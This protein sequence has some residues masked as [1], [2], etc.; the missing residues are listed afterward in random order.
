MQAGLMIQV[1]V[2]F[3]CKS[4]TELHYEI[5][6]RHDTRKVVQSHHLD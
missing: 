4:G 6:L 2:W 5:R 3:S 1:A